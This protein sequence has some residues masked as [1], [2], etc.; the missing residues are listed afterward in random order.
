ML[1]KKAII[2]G[3]GVAGLA[4]AI[5]L[6]VQ[7]FEVIVFEKNN[8][9][10]GKLSDFYK[11]GFHFDAGP[12]LFVQ[13]QNIEELFAIANENI[14]N[15]FSYEPVPIACKYFY[16]DGTIINAPS[17]TNLLAKELHEQLGEDENAVKAYLQQSSNIYEN[18]GT[19]FLNFSLHK[20]AT[21]FQSAIIKAIRKSKLRYLF[22]SMNSE[23]K[24]F[25]KNEKTVQLFNRYATYNGS[26]PYKAPAMLTLIPD[27]EF[28]N[29]VFYPKG[30]MISITKALYQL[31]LKKGVQF[32]FN[33]SVKK[34]IET[35]GIVK[36]VVVNDKNYFADI[37]VSNVDAY[38]TYKNL[39]GKT[40]R[41]LKIL[42][43]ERSSSAVIFYWGINKNFDELELH[44]IFFSKNYKAEFDSLFTTKKVYNDPTVYI[45]ITS[46]LE[47]SQ[48]APG[49][50]ENWFVMVNAPANIGQ[51]W[52]EYKNIYRKAII[53]KL[54]NI[55][56]IDVEPLIIT[57]EILDPVT[58][59]NKTSSYTGSLYGT[60][61]NSRLAAFL[62]HPNF[63]KSIKGLYF[64]GGSVHP[65]GGIPLCLHSAKIMSHLV[66][67]DFK[68]KKHFEAH[69]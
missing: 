47:P 61:S 55:L 21:L 50:K 38:F 9:P 63:S 57:E 3:S 68:T 69:H 32:H 65:G 6:A 8:Y 16:E 59:E 52:G 23:N 49:Q 12:S 1:P 51:N 46:K 15:Y 31:A 39:L 40:E 64:V 53:D 58:I 10:G 66:A 19:V 22:T 33:A 25:F 2:I 26:N 42:K 41:A 37:V 4:S 11:D 28:N 14:E 18:I 48:H 30:G 24:H 67:K 20:T 5:R 36:G 35:D 62:R 13:P 7:D 34:I 17:N 29:G 56:K 54:N 60:S 43:Q 44:N 27:L 45:N